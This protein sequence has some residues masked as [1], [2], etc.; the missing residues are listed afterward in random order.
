[1]TSPSSGNTISLGERNAPNNVGEVATLS[2]LNGANTSGITQT[3]AQSQDASDISRRNDSRTEDVRS[4][5]SGYE[6]KIG[7]GTSWR[8]DHDT[9]GEQEYTVRGRGRGRGHTYRGRARYPHYESRDYPDRRDYDRPAPGHPTDPRGPA[10][11]PDNPYY[12]PRGSYPPPVYDSRRDY[13]PD[14]SARY[15]E[16][17][18]RGYDSREFI[19]PPPTSIRPPMDSRR[20]YE[21]GPIPGRGDDPVDYDRPYPRPRDPRDDFRG[22]PRVPRDETLGFPPDTR[23]SRDARSDARFIDE[24]IMAEET[25]I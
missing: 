4:E 14:V 5:Q 8:R 20:P 9:L 12:D 18:R 19:P 25:E 24:G 6:R 23:P 21:R 22:D 3:A 13:P 16:D 10:Y 7:R 1:M 11:P 17:Y 2:V 15:H